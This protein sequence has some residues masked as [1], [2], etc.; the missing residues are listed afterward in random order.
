[1]NRSA[2]W[3]TTRTVLACIGAVLV[4]GFALYGAVTLFTR[5]LTSTDG[6]RAAGAVSPFVQGA[7]S[8]AAEK[9]KEALKNT[10]DD[11][12]E[13][14]SE[15]ISKK[16]YP[17]AKGALKGHLDAILKDSHRAEV[18]EKAFQAGKDLSEKVVR[19]FGKGVAEGS[20]KVIEDLDKTLKG[21][22]TFR[23]ENKDL[24]D[25]VAKGL[26]A[27]HK[28]AKENQGFLPPLPPLPSPPGLVQPESG[29][30]S[31]ESDAADTSKSLPR[32]EK[33]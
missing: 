19:P 12:L 26:D 7:A 13:K 5:S 28:A 9:A 8:V 30:R 31:P 32:D 33:R 4:I 1:V 20:G 21:M 3:I 29:P 16:L 27:L 24:L 6:E 25:A 15:D 23:E 2:F 17:I 22:R 14:D 10:P 11:R 18:P